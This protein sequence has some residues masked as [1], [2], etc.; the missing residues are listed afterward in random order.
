[1]AGFFPSL[2]IQRGLRS[3]V[4]S[5]V[6]IMAMAHTAGAEEMTCQPK[7]PYEA[8]EY[9]VPPLKPSQSKLHL[10]DNKDGTITDLNTGLMWTQKDSYADLKK[11]LT[12]P[13]SLEYVKNLKT[14]GHTDW[15]IPTIRE[16]ASIYNDTQENVMA[17]DHDP[18]YPLALDKKFSDGAAYWYWSSDCGTTALTECCAKTLYFVNGMVE[19][20]RF[21][22]CNNGGVRAVRDIP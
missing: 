13:E 10:F 20:R 1:M 9:I 15:R 22:L 11:C 7:P 14:S 16:L 2:R 17:W 6:L 12:W 18:D 3:S 4:L 21:E 19:I 5:F 8:P